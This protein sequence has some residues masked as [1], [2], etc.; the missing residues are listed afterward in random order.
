MH[1]RI[2]RTA[3]FAGALLDLASLEDGVCQAT[4]RVPVRPHMVLFNRDHTHAIVSFVASGHVGI[5]DAEARL[6]LACFK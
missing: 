2:G 6:P 4:G 3:A 1:Y 5:F